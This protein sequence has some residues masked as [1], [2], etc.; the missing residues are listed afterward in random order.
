MEGNLASSLPLRPVVEDGINILD[1][2]V[3]E[4]SES[5]VLWQVLR[6]DV[7]CLAVLHL[8]PWDSPLAASSCNP[9]NLCR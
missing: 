1:M 2:H 4:L 3:V 7:V 6:K 8:R 5:D 9:W